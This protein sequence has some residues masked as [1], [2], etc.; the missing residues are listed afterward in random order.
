MKLNNKDHGI[1]I[2]CNQCDRKSRCECEQ[3]RVPLK[4]RNT[5]KAVHHRKT[6]QILHLRNKGEEFWVLC[7]DSVPLIR[8][9]EKTGFT[10]LVW[11]YKLVL[12]M[13]VESHLTFLMARACHQVCTI[14]GLASYF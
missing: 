14:R 1:Q 10:N 6:F 13:P 9:V 3:Q 4:R 11:D 5:T 12:E 2:L 7:H 8:S